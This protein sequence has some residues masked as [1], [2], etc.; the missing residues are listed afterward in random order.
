MFLYFEIL[1]VSPILNLAPL[2]FISLSDSIYLFDFTSTGFIL[3]VLWYVILYLL[4]LTI[5]SSLSI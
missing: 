4:T 2:L 3:I 1:T 5:L